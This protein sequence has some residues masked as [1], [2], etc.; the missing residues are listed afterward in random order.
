[1]PR[2]WRRLGR[3]GGRPAASRRR[4]R[5]RWSK[6]VSRSWR[7]GS[8]KPLSVRSRAAVA[9]RSISRRA[10]RSASHSPPMR[11]R[12]TLSRRASSSAMSSRITGTVVR[13]A[14][15]AAT[16]RWWPAITR[17]SARRAST[18]STTPNVAIERVRAASSASPMRRG[19]PGSGC[20]ASIGSCSTMRAAAVVGT[21]PSACASP[22]W[23]VIGTRP[24][25]AGP[26]DPAGGGGRSDRPIGPRSG[27]PQPPTA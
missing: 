13:P 19:L 27:S 12:A 4:G 8:A 10:S 18:G 25:R 3:D 17:R 9:R 23:A 1:M 7:S 22:P 26:R 5:S 6:R 2:P 20:R 16:S 21:D 15:R 14:R 24:S 11:F